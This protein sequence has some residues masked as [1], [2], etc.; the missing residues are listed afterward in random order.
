VEFYEPTVKTYY[1]GGYSGVSIKIAKGLYYRTGA[2]RGNPVR[3]SEMTLIGSGL[4][5]I[6]NM[7]I[8]FSSLNKNF[9]IP[10]NKIITFNPYEDGLGLQK[11]GTTLKTA[12]I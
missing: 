4:L 1:R 12:N 5:G 2:F 3:S 8:F 6:T 7:H 11:D 9:R 10:Y